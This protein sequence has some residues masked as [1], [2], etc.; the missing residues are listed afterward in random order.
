VG[1]CGLARAALHA[2]AAYLRGNRGL[3]SLDLSG[4]RV[5]DEGCQLIAGAL[6]SNTQLRTLALDDT[7]L[8]DAGV[9]AL[10][11]LARQGSLCLTTLSVSCNLF[12]AVGAVAL[13]ESVRMRGPL[14]DLIL[15][16]HSLAP[17]VLAPLLE[18]AERAGVHVTAY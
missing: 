16:N 11:T 17:E 5:G 8:G 6:A 1:S 14:R 18:E 9:V 13:M 12:G 10:S 3:V 4:N 15:A 7:S 2:C